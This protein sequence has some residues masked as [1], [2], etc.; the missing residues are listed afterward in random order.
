[1][2]IKIGFDIVYECTQPTPMVLMLNVHP[3]RQ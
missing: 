2:Q 3:S 1:M